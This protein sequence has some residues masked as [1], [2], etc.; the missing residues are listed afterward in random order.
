[1]HP[2]A[3]LKNEHRVIEQVLNCLEKIAGACAQTEALDADS[4]SQALD[5]FR[6]FADCCHHT[7]EERHLFPLLEERGFSRDGGPTGVMLAEH[8]QCRHYCRGMLAAVDGAAAGN[9]DAVLQFV[10]HARAYVSLLREHIH[11]EDHCLFPMAEQALSEEDQRDLLESF[12]EVESDDMGPGTHEKYL[13][14]A[15]E[16]AERWGVPRAQGEAGHACVACGHPASLV[17]IRD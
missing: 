15:D 10:I 13:R 9:A 6:H 3:I 12:G 5:F 7:K 8:D 2:T 16:L 14:I 4:A 1:M 17:R 11:K